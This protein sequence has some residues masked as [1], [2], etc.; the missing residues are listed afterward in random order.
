[1]ETTPRSHYF[2]KLSADQG[3]AA[4]VGIVGCSAAGEDGL[5]LLTS[6]GTRAPS[7]SPV[8]CAGRC[9]GASLAR[10]RLLLS[11]KGARGSCSCLGSFP[12]PTSGRERPEC[13]PCQ[14]T[15]PNPLRCTPFVQL[16]EASPLSLGCRLCCFL[17][18]AGRRARNRE[19]FKPCP[20]GA[21]AC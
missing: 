11:L 4:C 13:V 9:L 18:Q 7:P 14:G 6:W 16:T 21:A 17:G 5:A 1:M 10:Q 8:V 3:S 12:S 20:P 19:K 15:G 2:T